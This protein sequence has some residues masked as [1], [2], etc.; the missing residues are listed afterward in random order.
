MNRLVHVRSVPHPF[1]VALALGQPFAACA[2]EPGTEPPATS[3]DAGSFGS[4]TLPLTS[5]AAPTA[6]DRPARAGIVSVTA[7]PAARPAFVAPSQAVV[8]AHFERAEPVADLAIAIAVAAEHAGA[9]LAAVPAAVE[10]GADSLTEVHTAL[11][12]TPHAAGWAWLAQDAVGTRE[13]ALADS[14]PLGSVLDVLGGAAG[15]YMEHAAKVQ[16]MKTEAVI[17]G[18]GAALAEKRVQTP[19]QDAAHRGCLAD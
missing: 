15:A 4:A 9:A 18:I 2:T 5:W 3:A 17:T 10:A 16:M 14:D 1:A 7:V 6:Q 19:E 11:A 12:T 13:V 8:R